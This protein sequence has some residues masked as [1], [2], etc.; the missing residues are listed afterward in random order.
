MS[1]EVAIDNVYKTYGRRYK[2]PKK[3]FEEMYERIEELDVLD[4]SLDSGMIHLLMCDILF[5]KTDK[6]LVKIL[7]FGPKSLEVNDLL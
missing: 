5:D 6:S 4:K 7:K 1:K 2:Q 3:F